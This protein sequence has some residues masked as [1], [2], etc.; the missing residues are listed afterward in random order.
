[1]SAHDYCAYNDTGRCRRPFIAEPGKAPERED[2][3]PR[4][5][6]KEAPAGVHPT[7]SPS[8]SWDYYYTDRGKCPYFF[9]W[10]QANCTM[11]KAR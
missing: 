6:L 1:M 8:G 7:P 3:A 10:R 11:S 5:V 2:Y 4:G 9:S